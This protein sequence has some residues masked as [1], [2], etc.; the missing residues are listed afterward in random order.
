MSIAD[1]V[2]LTHALSR[3]A[4]V[5]AVALSPS[6]DWLTRRPHTNNNVNSSLGSQVINSYT[7]LAQ[8]Y[9]ECSNAISAFVSHFNAVADPGEAAHWIATMNVVPP[10]GGAVAAT[11]TAPAVSAEVDGTEGKKTR[12]KKEKRAKLEGEPTRPAS[13]YIVFQNEMRPLLKEEFPDIKHQEIL[14]KVS[15]RWK[16]LDEA[17][18][19]VRMVHVMPPSVKLT[20]NDHRHSLVHRDTRRLRRSRLSS[21]RTTRPR[22]TSSTPSSPTRR[23]RRRPRRPSLPCVS[24]CQPRR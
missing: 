11:S 9:K 5:V 20:A 24:V 8:S 13:A 23:R 21:T 17:T 2:C 6:P 3:L 10:F 22:S 15:E 14:Q 7:K 19:K 4:C 16:N 12:R 1:F 18:K